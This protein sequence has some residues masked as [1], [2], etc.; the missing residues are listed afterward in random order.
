MKKTLFFFALVLLSQHLFSQDTVMV[1]TFNFD[2]ITTRRGIWQFPDSSQTY[3]KILMEYTLKC[4]PAT[5]QDGYNCGEWDYL[6]YTNIYDHTGVIDSNMMEHPYYKMV[7]TV[8]DTIETTQHSPYFVNQNYQEYLVVDSTISQIYLNNVNSP[9]AFSLA[10]FGNAKEGRVQ[11]YYS[12]ANI[13]P[14]G[15]WSGNINSISLK[16]GGNSQHIKNLTLKLKNATNNTT[17]VGFEN[18]GFTEVYKKNT[19]ITSNIWK[20]FLFKQDFYWDGTSGILIEFSY[21]G[22]ANF[23]SIEFFGSSNANTSNVF[24]DNSDKYVNI[25][26]EKY[27]NVDVTNL[28]GLIND[29]ITIAF[30]Q[31]GDSV[32]QPQNNYIF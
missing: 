4:D 32:I 2:S 14:T 11:F 30:W 19:D 16:F 13:L 3:R 26:G 7:N 25:T 10:N 21:T 22:K 20:K 18:S 17:D 24:A 9:S 6:T 8:L 1:Q 27:V 15:S 23:E 29:E 12:A 31:Y 28:S 5:T